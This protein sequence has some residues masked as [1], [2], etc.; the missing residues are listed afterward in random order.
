VFFILF[1]SIT[2][3]FVKE[4]VNMDSP[5]EDLKQRSFKLMKPS[6]IE[7]NLRP[8]ASSKLK[9]DK[10]SCCIELCGMCCISPKY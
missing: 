5:F 2:V 6:T 9:K 8:Q 7:G 1:V 3:L 4:T 10:V